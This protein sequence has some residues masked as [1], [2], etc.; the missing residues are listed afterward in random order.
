MLRSIGTA[1][2]GK[3]ASW[4]TTRQVQFWIALG[5]WCVFYHSQDEE[6]HVVLPFVAS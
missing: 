6:R 3:W 4:Q 5:G 1:Q 2:R